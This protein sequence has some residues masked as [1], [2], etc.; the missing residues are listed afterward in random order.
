MTRPFTVLAIDQGSHASRAAV[1]D[2]HG[3]RGE[4]AYRPVTTEQPRAG[5]VE[6]DAEDLVQSVR[7][8]LQR[9]T[10]GAT[11]QIRAAGLA[12][13]RSSIVCWDRE[14]GA[15]L[16]PVLSWRDRR[17]AD[18]LE[19]FRVYE[20]DIAERTGLPLSAH[21]GASKIAWCLAHLETARS[22]GKSLVIGP[23][24]SF[25]VHRLCPGTVP[26]V[27][28]ANA[29]RTLLY[30]R[31]SLDWDDDLLA[32]F[33]IGRDLL[34]LC[35]PTRH[36]YGMMEI[37]GRE[38]PL[39]LVTG[40]QAAAFFASGDSAAG[41]T[42]VNLGTGA[43]LQIAAGA[44]ALKAEG[45]LASIAY[46]DSGGPLYVL[47][48]TVNGAGSA[49]SQIAGEQGLKPG[50][51]QSELET[52]MRSV[53]DP[54]LFLN[55]VGGLGSPWWKPAFESRF[56]GNGD[57]AGRMV[58][59][60]ESIVFLLQANLDR[61]SEVL[62]ATWIRVSGGLARSDALCQR[63]ADLSGLSV[64]REPETEATLAGVAR[65][66]GT[67]SARDG[68]GE[69]FIPKDNKPLRRRYRRWLDAVEDA[70]EPPAA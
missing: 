48:G 68:T 3:C 65:L 44:E 62:P 24:A 50:L 19:R 28:P 12:T 9:V 63:L 11:A 7:E 10:T 15:A 2:D 49:L 70:L 53:E 23:L 26:Q 46:A 25:L 21:Y 16:S 38:I 39:A 57:S 58:A 52:W 4:I 35:V 1:Y 30:N 14:N 66:L 41:S 59:V 40:D 56:I 31:H 47:E 17:A 8:C 67:A 64:W 6:Q 33:G 27:D 55:G 13:Q 45:L 54:P 22:A 69:R 60:C 5:W 37:D 51:W 18:W 32:L 61:A 42:F 29:S 20:D 36:A 34:P 43:F